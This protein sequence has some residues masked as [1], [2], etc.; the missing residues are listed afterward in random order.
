MFVTFFPREMEDRGVEDDN[1]LK[2][3]FEYYNYFVLAHFNL[4]I[5]Q[6]FLGFSI[7]NTMKS[8]GV[9]LLCGAAS[10]TSCSLPAGECSWVELD[11]VHLL[12][13]RR[14]AFP[15]SA[16]STGEAPRVESVWLSKS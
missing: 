16:T 9:E 6:V 10:V 12:L 2:G 15:D 13:R 1:P 11:C 7:T 5:Y 14:N 3:E 4:N 8:V